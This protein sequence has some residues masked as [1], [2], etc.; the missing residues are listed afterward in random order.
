MPDNEQLN[1][2]EILNKLPIAV[3]VKDHEGKFQFVNDAFAKM[4]QA[5]AEDV[6]GKDD[7][8]FYD[9]PF[10]AKYQIEDKK[11]L[12]TG[13]PTS[14]HE[15]LHTPG[16][17]QVRYVHT[18]KIPIVTG[19]KRTGI[20]GMFMDIGA[21]DSLKALLDARA[22]AI[23]QAEQQLSTLV[24]RDDSP[25]PEPR[26]FISYKHASDDHQLWVRRL[27][28]DLIEQFGV[29]CILDQFDLDFGDSIPAYMQRIQTEATHVLFVITPECADAVESSSGGV[30]FE[31]QLATS[32]RERGKLR[33]IPVLR[34]GN[35]SP[36]YVQAHLYIDFRD[37]TIY[38]DVLRRLADSILHG[39]TRP[40]PNCKPPRTPPKE[41]S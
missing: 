38:P 6:I 14:S 4:A 39:K 40:K 23:D 22:K 30:S 28:T 27:A 31:M 41:A 7:W 25:K 3:F 12:D 16:D 10:A 1:A 19:D 34:A 13:V 29:H 26:V 36:A 20:L 33:I 9:T 2:E 11:V 15:I 32:L 35:Q 17:K 24:P 5:R 18:F 21:D 37:D 8:A